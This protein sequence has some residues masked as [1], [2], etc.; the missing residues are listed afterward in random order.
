MKGHRESGPLTIVGGSSKSFDKAHSRCYR[1]VLGGVVVRRK[2]GTFFLFLIAS[3]AL[4]S[5]VPRNDVPETAYNEAETPVNQAPP[6]VLGATLVHPP[7]IAAV[8][9][10]G[11]RGAGRCLAHEPLDH[12]MG[13]SLFPRDPH[14]LQDLLCT[15]LI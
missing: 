12:R 15:F 6:V 1:S 8:L 9:H 4:V 11:G 13:H 3:V 5:I 7:A 2:T 14:S 10:R